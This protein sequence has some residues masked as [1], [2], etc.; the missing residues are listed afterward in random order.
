MADQDSSAIN[1]FLSGKD[2]DK[3]YW[4]GLTDEVL[5][6]EFVWDSDSIP[7]EYANW[8]TNEP[9][10]SNGEDEDCVFLNGA[11]EG[12]TWNDE[13]CTKSGLFALCQRGWFYNYAIH[14]C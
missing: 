8:N 5:E 2:M 9:S 7:L 4:I 14:Y 13:S 6:G 1:L 3:L 11:I 10:S 12:R